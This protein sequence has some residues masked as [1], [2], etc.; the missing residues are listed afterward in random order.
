MP[1]AAD[2]TLLELIAE[3]NALLALGALLVGLLVLRSGER[4][5]AYWLLGWAAL[6]AAGTAYAAAVGGQPIPRDLGFLA[7]ALFAPLM[8]LGVLTAV[9]PATPA[10]P[11]VGLALAAGFTRLALHRLDWPDAQLALA[12]SVGPGCFLVAALA[13]MRSPGRVRFAPG[14]GVFLLGF[15]VFEAWDA[16]NDWT[17]SENVVAYELLGTIGIP[18]AALQLASRMVAFREDVES[19]HQASRDAERR[20]DIERAHFHAIFDHVRELVAELSPDARVL[21]VNRRAQDLLGL[22]TE[23]LIGTNA[24]DHVPE[25]VRSR[26]E[27]IWRRQVAM[28]GLEK[29]IVFPVPDANGHAI[30]L[31]ISVSPLQVGEERRL[32]VLARDVTQRREVETRLEAR[33]H[34]LEERVAWARERLRASQARLEDQDRLAVVGTLAAGIAHQINNPLGAIV[35]A[36]DFA[37]LEAERP[38]ADATMQ[39][40]LERI[41]GEARRAGRI[42]KSILRFARQGSASK[43]ID[44]LAAVVRRSVELCRPYVRER[45]GT[46]GFTTD[47]RALPVLMS[48]IEIEQLVVNLVRNAAESRSGGVNVQVHVSSGDRGEQARIEV[49]DD[50]CG[51]PAATIGKVFDPFYTTRLHEG[52]SGLGLAVAQAI[53]EDHAGRIEIESREGRGTRVCVVLPLRE[54]ATRP[55]RDASASGQMP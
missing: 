29:P 27:A 8:C 55:T 15:A 34:E 6:L 43:W 17:R 10:W 48:P 47:E 22:D 16:W 18:L 24:L 35:A 30:Y 50:G 37:L 11:L 9:R 7:D 23:G 4:P 28:S 40:A 46:L 3:A 38:D 13:L 39:E 26:G 32:L 31:E 21:Y 52:G 20:R 53:V 2:S 25:P 45:G 51:I 14:L 33:R 41:G 19:A 1:L 42:V 36:S 54:G 5:G 44:D 12:L 49:S